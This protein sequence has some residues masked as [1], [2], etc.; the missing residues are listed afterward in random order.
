MAGLKHVAVA[1][2]VLTMLLCPALSFPHRPAAS[3]ELWLQGI[4]EHDGLYIA[5]LYI[6]IYTVYIAIG[7][8][9]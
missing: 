1:G 2:L 3:N 7:L 6:Y 4:M 5:I 9:I 8:F